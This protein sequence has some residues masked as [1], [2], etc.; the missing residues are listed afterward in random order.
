MYY[1]TAAGIL[2]DSF[3]LISF[4]AYVPNAA[5]IGTEIPYSATIS[6]TSIAMTRRRS[7]ESI[8]MHPRWLQVV[9]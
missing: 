5:S 4:L 3:A 8:V 7:S 6:S 1:Q 9:L 2:D